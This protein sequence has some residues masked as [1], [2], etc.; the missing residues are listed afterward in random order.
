[1]NEN[2]NLA[3]QLLLVG[4]GSVFIILGIVVLVGRSLISLVNRFS[5][6]VEKP[7]AKR[8]TASALDSKKVAVL[9]AVVDVITQQRG[10]IKSV[11]KISHR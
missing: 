7:I 5:P 9:T 4:M 1:M 11:E 3:L 2:V 10:V 8:R 6:V